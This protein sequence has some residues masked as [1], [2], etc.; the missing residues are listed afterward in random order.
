MVTSAGD[1]TGADVV[2]NQEIDVFIFLLILQV[3]AE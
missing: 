3:E 2:I 1:V